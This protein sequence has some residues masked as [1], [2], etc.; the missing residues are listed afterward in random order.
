M[1]KQEF[2]RLEMENCR[3]RRILVVFIITIA[4]NGVPSG[5]L[6]P[7]LRQLGLNYNRKIR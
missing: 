6:R 5:P 3:H 7:Q 1:G 2:N 4:V